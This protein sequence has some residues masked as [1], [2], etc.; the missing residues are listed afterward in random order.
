MQDVGQIS[1]STR[2]NAR[3]IIEVHQILAEASKTN[4]MSTVRDNFADL[5][6]NS[7]DDEVSEVLF[8]F[9]SCNEIYLFSCMT[10]I[11][12][13]VSCYFQRLHDYDH[14]W[15]SYLK[16]CKRDNGGHL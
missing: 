2:N 3:E 6:N 10:I 13:I 11:I 8:E 14:F 12:L 1:E 15:S 5:S 7:D 4:C 16:T 9:I